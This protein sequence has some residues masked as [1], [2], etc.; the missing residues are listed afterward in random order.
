MQ[1][2]RGQGDMEPSGSNV[3]KAVG[4]LS[5]KA[6]GHKAFAGYELHLKS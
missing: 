3:G 5:T 2:C 6:D 1:K 4:Y